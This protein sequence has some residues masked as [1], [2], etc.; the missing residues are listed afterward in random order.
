MQSVKRVE[1][2]QYIDTFDQ[3]QLVVLP[4]KRVMS[5]SQKVVVHDLKPKEEYTGKLQTIQSI[6]NE[7]G[8]SAMNSLEQKPPTNGSTLNA[9]LSTKQ[10]DE[11][12]EMARK[13]ETQISGLNKAICDLRDD[14]KSQLDNMKDF[15][16]E[17]IQALKKE[18]AQEFVQKPKEQADE[19]LSQLMNSDQFKET[20]GRLN[21]AVTQKE[22]L[23][24]KLLRI[25]Q[26]IQVAKS[27]K[28]DRENQMKEFSTG[29]QTKPVVSEQP[30]FNLSNS[31]SVP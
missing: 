19:L 12:R 17:Q 10:L 13:M 16:T 4:E 30:S 20:V 26:K 21:T 6:P 31:V 2:P 28:E 14:H 5:K 15:Y 1:E 24:D 8:T 23:E 11:Q 3:A 27:I 18:Y 29:P 25:K 22:T 9:A 7:N